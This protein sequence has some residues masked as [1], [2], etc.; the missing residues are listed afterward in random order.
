[1]AGVASGHFDSEVAAGVLPEDVSGFQC[2]PGAHAS[3][4][5]VGSGISILGDEVVK[6]RRSFCERADDKALYDAEGVQAGLDWA[7][8]VLGGV[9]E[10]PVG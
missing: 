5:P 9:V 1:M 8:F 7:C 6:V 4:E 10:L 2:V 3:P